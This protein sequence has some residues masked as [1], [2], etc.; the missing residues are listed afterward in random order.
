[1][2]TGSKYICL[3][4]GSHGRKVVCITDYKNKIKNPIDFYSQCRM[5]PC[6]LD[7]LPELQKDHTGDNIYF[8]L[9]QKQK[10]KPKQKE[11]KRNVCP[12]ED[13]MYNG[14]RHRDSNGLQ[15]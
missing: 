9:K 5:R 6:M 11:R 2:T 3:F 12:G 14:G 10:P 15:G 8:S 4:G 13:T 7:C 1:M